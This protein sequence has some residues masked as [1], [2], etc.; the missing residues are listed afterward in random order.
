VEDSKSRFVISIILLII[1]ISLSVVVTM[2]IAANYYRDIPLV[3]QPTA[4]PTREDTGT[5]PPTATHLPTVTFTV[6]PQTNIQNEVLCSHSAAYWAAHPDAWPYQIVVSSYTYLKEKAIGVFN[7][8]SPDATTVLFIQFHAAIMNYLTGTNSGAVEQTILEASDWLASHPIGSQL[9]DSDTQVALGLAQ[10]LLDHNNGVT[11]PGVCEGDPYLLGA[12]G[13]LMPTID[14]TQAA[15]VTSTVVV[16]T[17]VEDTPTVTAFATSRP[18]TAVPTQGPRKK[19]P[20]ATSTQ[21]PPPTNT[22]APPTQPPP[23]QPPPPPPT[24]TQPPP[25]PPPTPTSAP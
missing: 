10:T 19:P 13:A 1:V 4:T 11:G 16:E 3:E 17:P 8:H 7:S 15:A 9:T 14:A 18:R 6:T 23:T 21:P 5:L 24:P 2:S 20:R 25:P 22:S 12:S